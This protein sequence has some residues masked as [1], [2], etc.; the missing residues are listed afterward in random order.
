T[1]TG[2]NVAGHHFFNFFPLV[3]VHLEQAADALAFVLGRVINVGTGLEASGID[4][5]E[6]QL[7]D[8]RIGGNLECET[9]ERLVIA[10]MTN[11]GV[12]TFRGASACLGGT[13]TERDI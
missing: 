11:G 12:A 2:G 8:E 6:G 3:G 7:T 4:A 13:T 9:G 10:R 1:D 5:E